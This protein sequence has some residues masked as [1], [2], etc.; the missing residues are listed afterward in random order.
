[1]V[2]LAAVPNPTPRRRGVALIRVSKEREG[3]VSPENQRYAIEQYADRAGIDIIEWIEGID[4]SGSRKKSAW[5]ARLDQGIER[6]EAGDAEVIVV[7][8]IDR[9]A[10][11]RLKWAVAVDRIETAGGYVESAT[12]PNDRSP[13]GRFSRGLMAEMAAFQAE[14]I[15][16]TWKEQLERRV[17]HGLTPS[18]HRRFGYSY[19]D[20]RHSID[21]IE[22]PQLASMYRSYIAGESAWQIAD[23]LNGPTEQPENGR[24]GRHARWNS[25]AV[26]RLLDAGFGA[27]FIRFRGELHPGAHDPVITADEWALYLSVR[28]ARRRR[29]R[30]ERSP[31]LYSGLVQCHCGGR[32]S[33]RTDSGHQRYT[34]HESAM[35]AAHPVASVS[36]RL[37]DDAVWEWLLKIRDD[38]NDA[39]RRAPRKP[40]A[41]AAPEKEIARRLAAVVERLDSATVKFIDGAIPQDAYTRLRDRFE[42]ERA[43]L[44]SELQRAS[45]QAV[46]RPVVFVGDLLEWWRDEGMPV[47]KKREALR[48][49]VDRIEVAPPDMTPRVRVVSDLLRS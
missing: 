27:G 42:A 32:M 5:W 7:W 25:V 40:T 38:L 6:V 8:R 13:A 39:A 2:R 26:L 33:G 30:A 41:V 28:A 3:M 49:L 37:I 17:R 45:A 9:T 16:A 14:S 15:G 31:Y 11:N 22:G 4:E 24:H 18:G 36:A 43:A 34:C 46:V 44:E 29:P 19:E 12:E 20:G 1:M 21:P 10:R 48:L 23:R 35:Y 47:E